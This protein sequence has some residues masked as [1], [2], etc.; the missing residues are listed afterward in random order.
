M[1]GLR[2]FLTGVALVL[3]FSIASF[4]FMMTFI[5]ENNPTSPIIN[6]PNINSSINTLKS[7]TTS[8]SDAGSYVSNLLSEAEPS[9]LY[10]FLIFGAAF[11]IPIAFI[12]FLA[13][14][15]T[16]II[17]FV[18]ITIFSGGQGVGQSNSYWIVFSVISSILIITIVFLIVRAIRT[19]E[20]ER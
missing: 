8:F 20:T 6:D 9:P 7:A 11:Y 15:I 4:T 16:G 3:L 19:G 17:T 5:G 2:P 12:A 13:Q 14:G 1:A 10:L 18:F